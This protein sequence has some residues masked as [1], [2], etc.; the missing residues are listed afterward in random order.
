MTDFITLY[1]CDPDEPS[2]MDS[3]QL[4]PGPLDETR[5]QDSAGESLGTIN[6]PAFSTYVTALY[7][8]N[9]GQKMH[10]MKACPTLPRDPTARNW[11]EGYS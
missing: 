1:I 4:N 11:R 3:A 7:R 8:V 10:P 5:G 9:I 6:I 2:R